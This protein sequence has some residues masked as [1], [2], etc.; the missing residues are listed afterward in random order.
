MILRLETG[1]PANLQ[2]VENMNEL[3]A[4]DDRRHAWDVAMD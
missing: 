1:I 4:G 2:L 3:L